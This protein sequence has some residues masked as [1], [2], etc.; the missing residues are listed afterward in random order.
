MTKNVEFYC[1][2]IT[3]KENFTNICHTTDLC[4]E[5][6]NIAISTYWLTSL[7]A[8]SKSNAL[9]NI[10]RLL[11]PNGLL[12]L[13]DLIWS[14]AHPILYRLN[15]SKEWKELIKENSFNNFFKVSPTSTPPHESHFRILF[16]CS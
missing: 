10:S 13:L 2:D 6:V 7:S 12:Y 15:Q 3:E 4:E 8:Y 16:F 5:S 9:Y 1:V 14:D 11:K